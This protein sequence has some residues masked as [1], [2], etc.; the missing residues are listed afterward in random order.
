LAEQDLYKKVSD[1]A[2]AHGIPPEDAGLWTL[3]AKTMEFILKQ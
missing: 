3:D 1:I 2:Q